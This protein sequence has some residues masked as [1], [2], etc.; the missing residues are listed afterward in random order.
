MACFCFPYWNIDNGLEALRRILVGN[1]D[2]DDDDAD[3]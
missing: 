3:V 1:G 2:D